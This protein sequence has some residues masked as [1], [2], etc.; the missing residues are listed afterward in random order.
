MTTQTNNA[1]IQVTIAKLI[2]LGGNEWTGGNHHRVY[3]NVD[4]W[5]PLAD[6]N[7]NY[8]KTG[9]ISGA[10]WNGDAISNTRAGKMTDGKM[11]FDCNTGE[12]VM[13]Y[14]TDT[15]A[16]EMAIDNIKRALNA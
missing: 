3:F 15:A 8:Y 16:V 9:N 5:A 13:Q 4:A 6:L 12:F 10:G 1:A 7:I 2:A 14:F 11:F